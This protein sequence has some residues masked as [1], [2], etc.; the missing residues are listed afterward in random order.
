[1]QWL[2]SLDPA[3]RAALISAGATVASV[4]IAFVGVLL[5]IRANRNRAR[6]DQLITLRREAYLEFCDVTAEAIQFLVIIPDPNVTLTNGMQ[7]M[8]KVSGAIGKLHILADQ[9]TLEV[10]MGYLNGFLDEYAGAAKLKGAFEMNAVE[11]NTANQRIALLSGDETVLANPL[12][13]EE[14]S[15][16]RTQILTLSR[17][18]LSLTEQLTAYCPNI[19]DRLS[20]RAIAVTLALRRD[21]NLI[22]DESWYR[23]M[24]ARN[25]ELNEK[26][27]Q[28][29]V[30]TMQKNLAKI[31]AGRPA[32]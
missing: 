19:I 32:F 9:T 22:V 3:T 16:L 18:N 20:A 25:L 2:F 12:A 13:A 15:K 28:P 6:E 10:V 17:D 31:R 11:I 27:S 5:T 7:V 8:R 23:Q 14:R 29:L 24:Q 26:R 30:E 1:M 21:L 4:T